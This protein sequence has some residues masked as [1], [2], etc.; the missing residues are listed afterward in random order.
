MINRTCR[1]LAA[2]FLGGPFLAACSVDM[3]GFAFVNNQTASVR[4]STSFLIRSLAAYT[5]VSLARFWSLQ[6][7]ESRCSQRRAACST[8]ASSE[9][10]A[11]SRVISSEQAWPS[12]LT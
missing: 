8:V 3:G 4:I 6:L 7:A 11:R 10:A 5:S 2:L 9:R 1:L 12:D